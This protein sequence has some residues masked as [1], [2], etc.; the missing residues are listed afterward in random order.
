MET[1]IA[2]SAPGKRKVNILG[3]KGPRKA[4]FLANDLSDGRSG[5]RIE[6]DNK[7]GLF[8]V[9]GERLFLTIKIIGRGSWWVVGCSVRY[10]SVVFVWSVFAVGVMC[11]VNFNCFECEYVCYCWI[12]FLEWSVLV[13]NVWKNI[14]WIKDVITG[15]LVCR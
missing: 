8:M 15:E 10:L 3:L 1:R 7:V 4:I 6:L 5:T 9:G 2:G 11:A 14:V 12:V 13:W